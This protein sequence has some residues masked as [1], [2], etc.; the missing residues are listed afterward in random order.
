MAAVAEELTDRKP[1]HEYWFGESVP[2]AMPTWIHGLLQGI[3]VQLFKE[4]GYRSGSEVKLKIS[5][6]FEPIPDVI[7][8]SHE[9]ELP[10]P[11]KPVDVVLEILSPEDSFQRVVRKCRLYAEWG[12]SNVVVLDPEGRE[13]WLWDRQAG[14]LHRVTTLMLSNG[15]GLPLQRVFDELDAALR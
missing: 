3:L 7:A 13:G 11:T 6:D 14:H 15:R 1:Y 5:P 10:Y 12:V 9:I 2:K 8:T 4:L